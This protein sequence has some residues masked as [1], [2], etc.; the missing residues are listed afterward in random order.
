MQTIDVAA[1]ESLL[2]FWRDAGVEACYVDAAVDRTHVELPAPRKAVLKATASV[3]VAPNASE[4]IAEARHAA[5]AA[6]TLEALMAAAAS[7]DGCGLKQQGAR[8]AVVGGGP[9]DADLLVIGAAPGLEEDDSGDIFA[10]KAGRLLDAMLGAA[11]L[12]DRAYRMNA[13]F[14]RPPGDRPAAPEEQAAC[15]PFVERALELLKPRAVLLLGAAPAR[16]VLKSAETVMALRGDWREWR[17]GEGNVSAPVR[18]TLNPVFLLKQGQAKKQAWADVLAV[19]ARLDGAGRD[20]G[21][22]IG[23]HT[24]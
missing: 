14:W 17:L 7:F 13:V 22:D 5:Q 11:G 6:T 15:L 9:P 24:D 19:A 18:V 10:G 12:K 20:A 8:R 1:A 4:C 3:A 2:A 21:S 23:P 16:S